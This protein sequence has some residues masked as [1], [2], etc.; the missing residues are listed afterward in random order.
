MADSP[1]TILLLDGASLAGLA[2][3]RSLGAARVRVIVSDFS[4]SA[5]AR[6]SRYCHEFLLYPS[7]LADPPEFRRWLRETLQRER[8]DVL[9]GCTDYTIPLLLRWQEELAQFCRVPL[10]PPA[11]FVRAFD[12]GQTMAQARALG[13][14]VP[15][16]YEAASEADLDAIAARC[17][18]PLVIKPR[19]SV[20]EGEARRETATVSYAFDA[21]ELRQKFRAASATAPPLVQEYVAGRGVGC[22]FLLHGGRV[23]GRFQH[24]RI[25]DKNPLGSG[26]CLRRSAPPNEALLAQ[27]EKLLRAMEWEG[28]AMVEYREDE[29]GTAWLMEVNPRPWGSLQLAITAGVNFPLLWW[30]AVTEQAVEPVLH[31]QSGLL[32]RYLAGDLQHV[33]SVLLGPPRGWRLPYP[34]RWETLRAFLGTGGSALRYDDFAAGDWRPGLHGLAQYAGGLLRRVARKVAG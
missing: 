18:W 30:R 15:A 7:P 21:D 20:G 34:A 10:P 19:S 28:L 16:Q 31:W 23:L 17:R 13:I 12:K 8:P 27:S 4:A 6:Y 29:A 24:Q 14:A 32:G 25:R 3:T 33:E 26:S 2:F 5:V 1:Q 11:A 9:A 22:F